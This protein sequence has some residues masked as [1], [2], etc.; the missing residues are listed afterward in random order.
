MLLPVGAAFGPLTRTVELRTVELWTVAAGDLRANARSADAHRRRG[1]RAA[2]RSAAC[3]NSARRRGRDGNRVRR[4]P[5]ASATALNRRGR[6]DHQ[7]SC[8][9]PRSGAPR[10]ENFLS[11]P[12]FR[13]GRSPSRGGRG[14]NGRSPRG[15]SPSLRKPSPRGVYGRFSPRP[16]AGYRAACRRISF[17]QNVTPDGHRRGRGA[18]DGRRG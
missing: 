10:E 12:N 8:A 11:P 14:L 4:D 18:A 3:R 2:C 16:R 1:R 6:G 17:R 15:R 13:S 7:N 9:G 5:R